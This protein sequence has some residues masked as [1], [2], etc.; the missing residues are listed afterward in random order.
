MTPAEIQKELEELESR[1]ER[2]RIK[3]DQ[4][5]IGIEKMLP[6]VQ[7][8]DVDRRFAQLH[9][10]QFRNGGLRFRF[11]TLVQRF[12]TY[13]TYWG[14]IIRQIEEGTYKRDLI[15]AQRLGRKLEQPAAA[16]AAEDTPPDPMEL[17]DDDIAEDTDEPAPRSPSMHAARGSEVESFPDFDVPPLRAPTPAPVAA[18][19]RPAFS[20]F[21]PTVPRA[22]GSPS[23]RPAPRPAPQAP[24]KPAAPSDDPQIRAL[25]QRFVEARR[26]T[27]ESTDVQYESI[28][29]QARETLPRLAQKYQGAEVRLDVS[30][31][32][33]KAVLKPIVTMPKKP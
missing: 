8:K 12:T 17:T 33:G 15:R 11:Q 32:D 29:R 20:A 7:R 5:F 30:I 24:P 6:F 21:G 27:G 2:L 1:L 16:A 22:A 19:A 28:A 9:K 3:Y 13:Q 26:I 31:K 23:L 14:R 10:E 18:S 25:H 4:Y